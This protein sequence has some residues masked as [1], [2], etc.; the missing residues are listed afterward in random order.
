MFTWNRTPPADWLHEL[1]LLAPPGDRVAHLTLFWESGTPAFPIQRW[2]IYECL[3]AAFVPDHYMRAFLGDPPCTC[4]VYRL[5]PGAEVIQ[6]LR[7]Q[8]AQ[9]PG[10]TRLHD[11][12]RR[13]RT[14]GMPLW[15]IQGSSGGHPYRFTQIEEQFAKLNGMEPDPPDPGDLPYAP[16]DRRVTS[17]LRARDRAQKAYTSLHRARDAGREEAE[18]VFRKAMVAFMDDAVDAAVDAI[19]RQHRWNDVP[20]HHVTASDP[21]NPAHRAVDYSDAA[22]QYIQ[23]GVLV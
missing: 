7:C 12:W 3:P 11:Y 19:P 4:P 22:A 1:A 20:V 13:T 10:R 17:R 5:M 9:S 23:T 18:I 16:F 15:V 8:R 6:C 2:V 21:Y 14:I